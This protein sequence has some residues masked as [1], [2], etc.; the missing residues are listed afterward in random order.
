MGDR[1]R[2]FTAFASSFA[3]MVAGDDGNTGRQSRANS[4]GRRGII[5][6][7]QEVVEDWFAQK[8]VC[9]CVVTSGGRD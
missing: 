9:G 4:L 7:Q 6:R 8:G 2:R 1:G 3:V 5:G